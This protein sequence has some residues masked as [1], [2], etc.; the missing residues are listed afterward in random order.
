M[1]YETREIK[2]ATVAGPVEHEMQD[3]VT[4]NDSSTTVPETLGS[5]GALCLRLCLRLCYSTGSLLVIVVVV[6][7]STQ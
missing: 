3:R 6:T 4:S 2:M 7:T 1:T 5:V